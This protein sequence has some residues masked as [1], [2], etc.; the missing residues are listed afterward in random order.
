[1]RKLTLTFAFLLAA[2][3]VFAQN[4]FAL[5]GKGKGIS[6]GNVEIEAAKVADNVRGKFAAVVR[7]ANGALGIR[8]QVVR[9]GFDANQP[10]LLHFAAD[11]KDADG[12][13]YRVEGTCLDGPNPERDDIVFT[14]GNANGVIYRGSTDRQVVN[15]RRIQR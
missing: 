9:L 11:C 1:M 12:N 8:G 15:V 2:S 4:G 14:I 6:I 5:H 3:F 13:S 10:H 7:T